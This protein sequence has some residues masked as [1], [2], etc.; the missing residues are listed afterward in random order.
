MPS[1]C[2]TDGKTAARLRQ[3]AVRGRASEADERNGI[4]GLRAVGVD[5]S[6]TRPCGWRRQAAWRPGNRGCGVG[7]HHSRP[8][9]AEYQR[10]CVDPR[11]GG[12]PPA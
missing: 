3:A 12:R 11:R 8:G 7:T 5:R 9:I 10:R 1:A 4:P 6:P 2:R